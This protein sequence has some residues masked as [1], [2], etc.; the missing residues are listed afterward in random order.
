MPNNFQYTP[1]SYRR[2]NPVSDHASID[3]TREANGRIFTAEE[4]PSI[5][6]YLGPSQALNGLRGKWLGHNNATRRDPPTEQRQGRGGRP[7]VFTPEARPIQENAGRAAQ[8]HR[9]PTTNKNTR[10]SDNNFFSVV[11]RNNQKKR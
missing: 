8:Q 11:G 7:P 9:Q 1:P 2:N 10:F 6:R 5:L 3:D 4:E